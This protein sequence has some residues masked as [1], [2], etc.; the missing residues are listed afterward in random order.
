MKTLILA[1]SILSLAGCAGTTS[2]THNN[3]N[4]N[5]YTAAVLET[6]SDAA[7]AVS[8]PIGRVTPIVPGLPF[9]KRVN[10]DRPSFCFHA[11]KTHKHGH[12]NNAGD[13]NGH[14]HA[15]HNK[16]HGHKNHGIT[17]ITTE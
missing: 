5:D 9:D 6:D 12:P 4:L 7:P 8:V 1:A 11:P 10:P 16:Q 13:N 3:T 15:H 2:L 14:F 17:A